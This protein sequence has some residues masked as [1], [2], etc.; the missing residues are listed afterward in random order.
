MLVVD[1]IS[2]FWNYRQHYLLEIVGVVS[3]GII[4]FNGY[5]F[6]THKATKKG[7]RE[8]CEQDSAPS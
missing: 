7:K 3:K 4:Q 6:E 2:H 8:G 5:E 1:M